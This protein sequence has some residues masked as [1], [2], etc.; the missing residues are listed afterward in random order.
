M[1][2]GVKNKIRSGKLRNGSEQFQTPDLYPTK[3]PGSSP[4]SGAGY[5]TTSTLAKKMARPIE[6]VR[7]KEA[8]RGDLF[9]PDNE[10]FR[11]KKNS[12]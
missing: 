2:L 9:L 5:S 12:S 3:I 7:K 8:K 6:R 1:D 4:L 11:S 10:Q